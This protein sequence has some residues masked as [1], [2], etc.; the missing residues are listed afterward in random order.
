MAVEVPLCLELIF[1]VERIHGDTRVQGQLSR[2]VSVHRSFASFLPKTLPHR[3]CAVLAMSLLGLLAAWIPA[4]RAPSV[5]P[6][7]LLREE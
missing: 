5:D 1:D 4:Q 2:G 3:D 6:L 7:I